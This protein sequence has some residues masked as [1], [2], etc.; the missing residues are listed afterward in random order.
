MLHDVSYLVFYRIAGVASFTGL[1]CFPQGHNFKQWTGND[2]KA[3]MK[4]SDIGLYLIHTNMIQ[5]G[6]ST[7]Y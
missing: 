4:A 3:L 2:S 5:I 7:S 6:L 1:Q